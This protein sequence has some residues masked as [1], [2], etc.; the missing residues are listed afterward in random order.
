ME[1]TQSLK[2]ERAP[3]ALHWGAPEAVSTT[4]GA[5]PDFRATRTAEAEQGNLKEE[6]VRVLGHVQLYESESESQSVESDC[7]RPHGL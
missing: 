3:R 2:E 5:R 4:G 6:C 7:V 1:G